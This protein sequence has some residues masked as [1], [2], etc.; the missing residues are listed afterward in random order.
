MI[1]QTF[2][3]FRWDTLHSLSLERVMLGDNACAPLLLTLSHCVNLQQFNGDHNELGDAT[4]ARLFALFKSH[5][6]LQSISLTHNRIYDT[7]AWWLLRLVRCNSLLTCV[8]V[9]H[10]PTSAEMM[11]HIRE[12]CD[13]NRD[14]RSCNVYNVFANQ[15]NYLTSPLVLSNEIIHKATCVWSA[16]VARTVG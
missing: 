14:M 12:A 13:K 7:G 2:I 4:C 9:E 10:N 5:R 8:N 1:L 16:L 6:T 3:A 15:Y 11:H